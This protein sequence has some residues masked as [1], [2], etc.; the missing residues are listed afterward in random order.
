MSTPIRILVAKENERWQV[1][2]AH[3]GRTWAWDLPS[4]AIRSARAHVGSLREG[5]VH[6]IVVLNDSGDLEAT[7]TRGVDSFP[8]EA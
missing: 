7:W 3:C 5:K 2:C 1:R 6:Q 8:P 4:E